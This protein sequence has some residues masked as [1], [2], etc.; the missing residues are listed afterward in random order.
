[1]LPGPID[2]PLRNIFARDPAAALDRAET[3]V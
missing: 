2:L 1:M 3:P